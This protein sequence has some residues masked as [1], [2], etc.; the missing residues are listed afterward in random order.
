MNADYSA[1]PDFL[2]KFRLSAINISTGKPWGRNTIYRDL[3]T[4]RTEHHRIPYDRLEQWA[5]LF[6]CNV[7]DLK[8]DI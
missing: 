7:Q 5:A 3:N 1:I 4:L 8:N 6:N 2:Q